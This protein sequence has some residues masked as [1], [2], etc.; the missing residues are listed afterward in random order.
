MNNLDIS[1]HHFH[2]NFIDNADSSRGDG[3]NAK[4]LNLKAEL[5]LKGDLAFLLGARRVKMKK[6]IIILIVLFASLSLV[7][8]KGMQPVKK[9]EVVNESL[10]VNI[11]DQPVNVNLV[12]QSPDYEYEVFRIEDGS[13]TE[14]VV[15][16]QT[17]IN[18]RA[19]EGWELV[20]FSYQQ[21]SPT[22]S[23]IYVGIMKRPME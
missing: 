12:T 19:S 1:G 18:E 3:Q 13:V 20:S 15:I 2:T 17:E 16:F 4:C 22:T 6:L 14:A 11:Q 7:W 5:P 9:V 23:H 8:G 21:I 10:N